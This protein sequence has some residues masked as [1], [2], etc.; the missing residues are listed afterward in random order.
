MLYF[1]HE[2]TAVLSHGLTKE[3]GVPDREI[4]AAISNSTLFRQ[5]REKHTYLGEL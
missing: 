4:E 2:K 1:F 5:A 3:R